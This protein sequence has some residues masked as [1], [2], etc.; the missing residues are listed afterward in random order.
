MKKVNINFILAI[1]IVVVLLVLSFS[2]WRAVQKADKEL[3]RIE[4]SIDEKRQENEID[5]VEGHGMILESFA[6]LIGG[7]GVILIKAILI[8][9]VVYALLLFV[10]ALAARLVYKDSGGRL[11]AYRIIMGIEYALQGIMEVLLII[12]I[13]QLPTIGNVL[14]A[15]ILGAEIIYGA[16]N[17]YTPRIYMK[18]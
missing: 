8:I 3:E 17:T 15:V 14:G 4:S 1:I 9:M 16:I 5:D 2:L 13:T 18:I 6:Y 7:M 10:I 11:L 12:S